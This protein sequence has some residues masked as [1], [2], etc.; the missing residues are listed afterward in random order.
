M[1]IIP[2][3]GRLRQ[4]D[5]EF[6]VI[7]RPC[8]EIKQKNYTS[9]LLAHRLLNGPSMNKLWAPKRATASPLL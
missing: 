2:A 8:H 6:K 3:L 7:V 9:L 5:Y 4:K 1:A